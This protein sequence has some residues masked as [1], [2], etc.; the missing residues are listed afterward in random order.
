MLTARQRLL[1]SVIDGFGGADLQSFDERLL[2]QK[3]VYLLGAA[4]VDLGYLH[5]WYIRGPY[6]PALARDA[7]ACDREFRRT[8]GAV[9][10]P[11]PAIVADKVRTL[12]DALGQHWSDPR[13]LE[14]LASTIFLRRT[15][16]NESTLTLVETLL[17]RK[18]KYKSREVTEAVEIARANG[19][20]Q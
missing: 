1:A 20:W 13:R 6:C 5:G 16:P 19:W 8:G 2:L 7:F 10:V 12:R 18:P 11:L 3:R 9:G 17:K 14:L 15:T 4:G